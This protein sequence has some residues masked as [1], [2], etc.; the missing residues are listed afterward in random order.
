MDTSQDKWTKHKLRNEN[1]FLKHSLKSN[2]EKGT[3]YLA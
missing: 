1:I 2:K 3:N